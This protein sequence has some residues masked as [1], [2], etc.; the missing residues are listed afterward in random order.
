MAAEKA[1]ALAIPATAPCGRYINKRA[2]KNKA[3]AF[4]FN[5][6]DLC[7][8]VSGFHKRKKKR[9]KEAEKQQGEALRRKLLE[10]RKKRKLEKE[11]A[12][13]G[14]APPAAAE[15]EEDENVEG[16]ASQEEDE[17]S[18]PDAPISGTTTYDNDEIKVTVTTSEISQEE[19]VH[20]VKKPEA[21][22]PET[23]GAY[24]K[25]NVPVSKKKPLKKVGKRKSGPKMQ[26][27][28]DKRKGKEKGSKR[29]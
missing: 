4:T 19:E 28:R 6:K 8:F 14:G 15:G 26:K 13:F 11:L 27:K 16:D 24:K 12:L 10:L 29:R 5:E 2:L 7:D 25:H 9:R 17:D 1:E 18:E 22:V 20:P 23:V 3:I 21:V